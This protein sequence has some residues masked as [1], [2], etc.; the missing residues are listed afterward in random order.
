[1]SINKDLPD[2]DTVREIN[3]KAE[4][5][6][7]A[8]NGRYRVLKLIAVICVIAFLLYILGR[9]LHIFPYISSFF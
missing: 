2:S 5:G 4:E 9:V 6:F 1:M 3:R 7:G 8:D